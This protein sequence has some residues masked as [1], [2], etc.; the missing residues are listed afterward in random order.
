MDVVFILSIRIDTPWWPGVHSNVTNDHP[1]EVSV[2]K[3][4]DI[5]I[6]HVST[7]MADTPMWW[8]QINYHQTSNLNHT[9]VGNKIV[10]HSDVVGASR[11]GA[12]PTTSSF[13]T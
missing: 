7:L 8:W 2:L 4:M 10:A 13:S 1:G 3:S 5:H 9:F 12:A 11:V 6:A